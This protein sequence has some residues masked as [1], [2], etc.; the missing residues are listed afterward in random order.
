M[1]SGISRIELP[2][3]MSRG[4]QLGESRVVSVRLSESLITRLDSMAKK[5]YRNRSIVIRESLLKAIGDEYSLEVPR[6][7]FSQLG[8]ILY[9]IV[10][11]FCVIL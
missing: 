10:T 4:K 3:R 9:Y 5:A 7:Q 11:C 8:R 6:R 1:R 2:V